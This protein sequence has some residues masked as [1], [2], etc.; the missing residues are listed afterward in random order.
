FCIIETRV[1]QPMFNLRLFRIP[2]FAFGNVATLMSS[3]SR[4]GLQFMLIIWLQGIWL[5][6]HG[7]DYSETPL[8]SAI[9][10]VPL[11]VGFLGAAPVAGWLSDRF[12][13][14]M[15]TTGGLVIVAVT[16]AALLALPTDF[17]YWQFAVILFVSGIGAGLFASPN[18]TGVMNSLPADQRGA[19]SGMLSTLQ[20]SGMALSIGVFFSTLIAGLATTMPA[21]LFSGLTQQNVPATVASNVANLPPVGTLFAAFLGYNPMQKILGPQVLAQLPPGN[22]ATVV[23]KQFFPQLVAD[24][25]HHGLVIVFCTAI[26]ISLIGAIASLFRGPRY[27]HDETHRHELDGG[28][29]FQGDEKVGPVE[30][31]TAPDPRFLAQVGEQRGGAARR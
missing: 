15:F 6:L 11:T 2:A 1:D 3:L 5:P 23:G 19:G 29:V 8:W 14:R 22:A 12:G 30:F 26:A 25:F 28:D 9:Y 21:A 10:M 7:Y 24:S 31:T 18:M 17:T 4:G 13:A 27:V 20:N 16:F